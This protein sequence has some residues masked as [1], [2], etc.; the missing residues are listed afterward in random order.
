MQIGGVLNPTEW[1]L[2]DEAKAYLE[3]ARALGGQPEVIRPDIAL[4]VVMD[5]NEL[6]AAATARI[7]AEGC[8]VILVGGRDRKRWLA[9]LDQEIGSAAAEAGATQML[10]CGR[11]GWLRELK[12]LGWDSRE[13]EDG[14][15]VYS[16][17]LKK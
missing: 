11:R 13:G 7:T 16:R 1:H 9:Q 6:L 10:A 12:R 4:W 15:I 2:W 8:E 5:G 17:E 14:M 3:P